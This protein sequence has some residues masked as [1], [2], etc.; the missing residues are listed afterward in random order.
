MRLRPMSLVAL[1]LLFTLPANAREGFGFSK[2]AV[3]LMRTTPPALNVTTSKLQVTASAERSRE[4]DDAQTLRR[5]AE[6][7]IL[8]GD[9]RFTAAGT[10]DLNVAIVLDHLESHE[11]WETKKES[12]YRQTGTREEWNSKK[13]KYEEKPVYGYVNVTK[14]VKVVSGEL[15]GSCR[16]TE[17]KSGKVLD[18]GALTNKFS[19]KYDNG[20]GSPS[21]DR[22]EDDLL[23]KAARQVASRLVPTK[24]RVSIL[25]PKG[26]FEALIP[27][28]ESGA[29]DR[30][31]AGVQA[32]PEMR[33]RR[34]EAYRQ[35]AQGVAKEAVAYASNDPQ[36]ALELLRAAATHYQNATLYNPD[37]TLFR[38]RY[39]SILSSGPI[40]PPLPRLTESVARYEAWGGASSKLSAASSSGG[41]AK[42]AA[43]APSSTVAKG[44]GAVR[45]MRNETVIEMAK[46]GLSDENIVLAIDSAEKTQFDVSPEALITLAKAGVS[47]PVIAVM[48]KVT[49]K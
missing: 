6:E 1:L 11:T 35:Y 39:S 15:S 41:G 34:A 5:Y 30:Y 48:Q 4:A 25:L 2:K 19:E 20:V 45:A 27:L 18:S 37:E 40:D 3:D 32:V 38:E 24:D 49:K 33:D 23:H 36:Q 7:A 9:S 43:A 26:S 47:R 16:I 31:L 8:A 13:G 14:N 46:A 29:W 44:G 22:V 12:E 17:E 10:P 42:P 21:P 28:A